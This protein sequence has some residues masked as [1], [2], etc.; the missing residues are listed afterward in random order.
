MLRL[1]QH[2]Q[3][4]GYL[5]YTQRSLLVAYA[6]SDPSNDVLQLF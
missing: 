2:V 1:L 3:I 6:E 4:M 5:Q